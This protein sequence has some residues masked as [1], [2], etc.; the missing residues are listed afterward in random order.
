MMVG[1]KGLGA[2]TIQLYVPLGFF[3]VAMLFPF[4]VGPDARLSG[5]L[6]VLQGLFTT[7]FKTLIK[8]NGQAFKDAGYTEE[9]L[10]KMAGENCL[11]GPLVTQQ[12]FQKFNRSKTSD[13]VLNWA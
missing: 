5:V 6:S 13:D 2:R 12:E 4:A 8:E 7:P 1:G 10:A 9:E 3:L 11:Q